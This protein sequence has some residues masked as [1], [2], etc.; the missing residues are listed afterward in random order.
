M[1]TLS[2]VIGGRPEKGSADRLS[3]DR[4]TRRGPFSSQ[5]I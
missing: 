5:Y 3:L 4:V 2:V 1:V